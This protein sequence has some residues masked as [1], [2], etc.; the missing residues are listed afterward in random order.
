MKGISQLMI[1][2]GMVGSAVAGGIG[3]ATDEQEELPVGLSSSNLPKAN[4]ACA[5]Q[6]VLDNCLSGQGQVL[7]MCSYS[8]WECKC[9]AQKGIAGCF[10]NCPSDNARA[11]SEG[12]ID[13]YCGAA[14]RAKE[15]E[16][17]K[18]SKTAKLPAKTAEISEGSSTI[19]IDRDD[20]SQ[21]RKGS[22]NTNSSASDS[23]AFQAE[24]AA[25]GDSRGPLAALALGAAAWM[26][27]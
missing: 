20:Q 24:S 27:L 19:G 22:Q 14:K 11:A 17:K 6:N 18:A 7:A 13:V 15:E 21:N 2:G 12:Q 10:N 8:D 9:Q 1:I 4:K 3:I 5:A 26:L 23:G 25:T 16:E